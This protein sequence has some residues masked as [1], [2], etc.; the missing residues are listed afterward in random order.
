MTGW[1]LPTV[2]CIAA[3]CSAL[4]AAGGI[5]LSTP[6]LQI[7]PGPRGRSEAQQPIS[8][9]GRLSLQQNTARAPGHA[10]HPG[11]LA[12]GLPV[13]RGQTSARAAAGPCCFL[14]RS[15]PA[16]KPRCRGPPT[17]LKRTHSA[18]RSCGRSR[19]ELLALG[20]GR[21]P[22]P[23]QI[24]RKEL[25]RDSEKDAVSKYSIE[26]MTPPQRISTVLIGTL[27][28]RRL[29]AACGCA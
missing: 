5:N 6:G 15:P 24:Q 11:L 27:L 7:G 28:L 23:P 17:L 21:W 14:R 12:G 1:D 2:S 13:R 9:A 22:W 19:G 18:Q 20:P 16:R 10:Y 29:R 4:A 26:H 3:R 25:L 8:I